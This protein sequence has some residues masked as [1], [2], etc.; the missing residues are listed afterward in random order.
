M[1]PAATGYFK[2]VGGA[3]HASARLE[4]LSHEDLVALILHHARLSPHEI[5][6]AG[7]VCTT[8]RTAAC[9][10]FSIPIELSVEPGIPSNEMAAVL[11]FASLGM[12][13]AIAQC[14]SRGSVERKGVTSDEAIVAY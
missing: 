8:W 14:L 7:R 3:G 1:P 13:S 9:A 5:V 12:A 6:Y 2:L 11:K 4:V 10:W